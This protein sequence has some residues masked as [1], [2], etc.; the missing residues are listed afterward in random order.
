MDHPCW[1]YIVASFSGTL[2]RHHHNIEHRM[3]EHKSGK[4]EGFARK[5]HRIRLVYYEGFDDTLGGFG[6]DAGMEDG[7]CG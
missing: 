1:T 7:L 3:W 5:Y 4:F 2:Y 6:G